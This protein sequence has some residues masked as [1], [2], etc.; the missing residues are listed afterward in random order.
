MAIEWHNGLLIEMKSCQIL[1]RIR[2]TDWG[3]FHV[4]D[5][6]PVYR[7][8]QAQYNGS[9]SGPKYFAREDAACEDAIKAFI[10]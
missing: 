1:A 2:E 8:P 5:L 4:E 9:L 7:D 3:A 6:R 10:K